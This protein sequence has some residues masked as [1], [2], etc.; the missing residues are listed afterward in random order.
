MAKVWLEK[1]LNDVLFPAL[2]PLTAAQEDQIAQV[3]ETALANWR[4]RMKKEGSLRPVVTAARNAIKARLQLTPDNQYRDARTGERRHLALKY[5][6]LDWDALNAVSDEKFEERLKNQQVIE[7]PQAII[8][9]AESLLNSERWY[10][11]VAGLALVTGRRLGEL[12]KA[13]RF[14]PKTRYTVVFSGQLKRR[15]LDVKPYEIPVLVDAEK[16]LAAWRKLRAMEDTSRLDIDQVEQKYSRDASA[17][18]NRHF[19]GL[20]PQRNERENL[21]THGFRAVYAQLAVYAFC[22]KSVNNMLYANTIL[23]QWQAKNERQIRDFLTTAHYFDYY[24]DGGQG[25]RLEEPGVEILEAFKPKGDRK[26]TDATSTQDQAAQDTQEQQPVLQ[27]KA[28]KSRGALTTKPD[29]QDQVI[30]LMRERGMQKHDEIVVDLLNHDRVAHQMYAL[31]QP[32]APELA[33]DEN[34]PV[35]IL[36]ALINAYRN[37][38][39][40]KAAPG[41]VELLNE[42]TAEKKEPVNYLR[43]LVER[44]RKFQ[45][46]IDRRGL[47]AE[48]AD[49][50]SLPM[51][52]LA[53]IKNPEAANERFRRAVDAIIRH[54]NEQTDPLHLWYANAAAVRDLVG[55]RNDAVQA[56]LDTRQ[57]ELDEHHAKWGLKPRQNSKPIDIEDEVVVESGWKRPKGKKRGPASDDDE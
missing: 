3:C 40:A 52:E 23:G 35:A 16:V 45:A 12:L 13:G 4:S 22:P 31:L 24:V 36:Q 47:K 49:Y 44:D 53:K 56:Y 41:L 8:N 27:T 55:G 33:Q 20:I 32:L 51:A 21:Y 1:Y 46:G 39:S 10:D 29:T 26:M 15:D 19:A 25:N 34:A 18:A 7:H 9:R 38:G 48:Q 6:N 54:N 28:K 2:E 30:D 5:I 37:G 57:Q 50:S 42:V 43:T 17:A 14:F 11:L